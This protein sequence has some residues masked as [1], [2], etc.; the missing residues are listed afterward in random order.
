[1]DVATDRNLLIIN[2]LYHQINPYQMAF[3]TRY[4]NFSPLLRFEMTAGLV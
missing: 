3:T 2:S 1:M 4:M